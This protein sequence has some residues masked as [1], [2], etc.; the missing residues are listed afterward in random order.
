MKSK[1][2][3]PVFLQL[4]PFLVHYKSIQHEFFTIITNLPHRPVNLVLVEFGGDWLVGTS[5]GS[6][7]GTSVSPRAG[8]SSVLEARP[9][10][11]DDHQ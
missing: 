8:T 7:E 6:L 11:H 4:N 5:G 9:D 1:N 10:H 2:S 3:L